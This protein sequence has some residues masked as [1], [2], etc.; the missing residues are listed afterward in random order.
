MDS[1]FDDCPQCGAEL[2]DPSTETVILSLP[3]GADQFKSME[4]LGEP[5]VLILTD[6]RIIMIDAQKEEQKSGALSGTGWL[7]GGIIGAAVE[8][9]IRGAKNAVDG[10]PLKLREVTSVQLGDIASLTVEE[11][12]FLKKFRLFTISAKENKVYHVAFG[13]K[14]AP[15][16]EEEIRTRIG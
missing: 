11:S 15:E 3:T 5:I 1:E 6:K 12:G 13:K 2:A 9:A 14:I 8:G 7:V 16:W 4:E 10:E